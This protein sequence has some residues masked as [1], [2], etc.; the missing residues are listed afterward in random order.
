MDLLNSHIKTVKGIDFL[1]FYSGIKA[2]CFI[3]KFVVYKKNVRNVEIADRMEI[4][5][6][7][8][9]LG[10]SVATFKFWTSLFFTNVGIE[11]PV[12]TGCRGYFVITLELWRSDILPRLSKLKLVPRRKLEFFFK[13]KI[14]K[15]YQV[16]SKTAPKRKFEIHFQTQ[17]STKLQ[18]ASKTAP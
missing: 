17:N 12:L 9:S 1:H 13:L 6:V 14:K 11:I 3:F 10:F 5:A 18:V 15:W 7:T 4:Q 8:G 16:T 2:K